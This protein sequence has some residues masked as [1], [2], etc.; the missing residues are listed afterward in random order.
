[1][2][3]R[4]ISQFP[5]LP[6]I[7]GD[8]YMMVAYKG[9][10]YK[11]PL[12]LITGNSIQSITQKI[13]PND[14]GKHDGANNPITIKVGVGADTVEYN[15]SVYNGQRGSKG[16][17]GDTGEKGPK[18]DTGIAMYNIADFSDIIRNAVNSG[19]ESELAEMALSAQMG[20][21][22]NEKLEELEEVYLDSQED[23]DALVAKNE[24][25]DNVKYFIFEN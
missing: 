13:T 3:V 25:K 9:K 16:P 7:S 2:Q 12:S 6:S 22:L 24:I 1:M 23:Y 17:K 14:D 19:D 15:F 5:N 4:K 11:I 21:E 8:E 10:S 18:G 20:V